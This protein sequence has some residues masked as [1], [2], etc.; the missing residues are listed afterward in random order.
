MTGTRKDEDTLKLSP[1]S[2]N[3]EGITMD[4][5]IWSG[6]RQAS[7]ICHG[8]FPPTPG[9][10]LWQ[11]CPDVALDRCH[12]LTSSTRLIETRSQVR[13]QGWTNHW[14]RLTR[15][16]IFSKGWSSLVLKYTIN[17]LLVKF[18]PSLKEVWSF[19]QKHG[20]LGI[21]PVLC[22][23]KK[24]HKLKFDNYVLFGRLAG[25]LSLGGDLSHNSEGLLWS[26]KKPWYTGVLQQNPGGWNTKRLR[27]TKE[28]ANILKLVRAFYI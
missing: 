4:K 16:L 3:K 15:L 12:A 26:I 5:G 22:Q 10:L 13:V 9:S 23:L 8:D 19:L 7:Y 1:A 25:D 27:L 18:P 21:A 24:M 28:K 20:A 11:W 14:H 2:E 6:E 17:M